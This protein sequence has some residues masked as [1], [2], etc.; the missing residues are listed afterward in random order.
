M[1]GVGM[2]DHGRLIDQ[3]AA[4]AASLPMLTALGDVA[5]EEDLWAQANRDPDA[6]LAE[7]GLTIPGELMVKP[8]PW[9]GFG[10]PSPEWEPFTIRLTMCRT[11]WIRGAD[12]RYR[13][14]DVCRG[15]AIVPHQV[16]GGPRG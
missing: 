3:A 11:V 2:D 14:E 6:F 10:R 8:I 13:E 15:F 9:P 12:G 16:P 1:E 5:R 7:R 4:V